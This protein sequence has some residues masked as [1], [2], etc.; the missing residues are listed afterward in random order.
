MIDDC[1]LLTQKLTNEL[2]NKYYFEFSDYLVSYKVHNKIVLRQTR[3][4]S[5]RT[6]GTCF[7]SRSTCKKAIKHLCGSRS[8]KAKCVHSTN[9]SSS[10]AR[11]IIYYYLQMNLLWSEFETLMYISSNWT[12]CYSEQGKRTTASRWFSR[13]KLDCTWKWLTL[14]QWER[15]N[16]FWSERCCLAI[17]SKWGHSSRTKHTWWLRR[18]SQN[19]LK[20]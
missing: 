15:S 9:E 8:R 17:R 14:D 5:C 3:R 11:V 4:V 1:P 18:L 2:A 19:A 20:C 6:L 12:L 10:H 7:S 16:W 13:D